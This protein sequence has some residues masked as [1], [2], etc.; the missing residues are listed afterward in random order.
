MG[1]VFYYY[2]YYLHDIWHLIH[3]HTH[4]CMCDEAWWKS[5][6]PTRKRWQGRNS[7]S[8]ASCL[9]SRVTTCNGESATKINRK[10]DKVC[11]TCSH[12]IL[13]CASVFQS[14]EHL[15]RKVPF[16]FPMH[17]MVCFLFLFYHCVGFSEKGI[18]PVSLFC[19]RGETVWEEV[20]RTNCTW[21]VIAY[22]SHIITFFICIDPKRL[23][24]LTSSAV[25][26]FPFELI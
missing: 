15:L 26:T 21:I 20:G 14:L 9:T 18:R 22:S 3:T 17:L 7:T 8:C 1:F 16:S 25:M 24:R 12:A 6:S 13:S 23:Y 2:L 11:I 4:T 5:W 10:L 19:V